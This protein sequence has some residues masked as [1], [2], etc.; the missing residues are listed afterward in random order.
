MRSNVTP[1][2]FF[3]PNIICSVL[4]KSGFLRH[5]SAWVKIR[6][7]VVSKSKR[8]VN[9]SS[10]FSSFFIFTIHNYFVNFRFMY[11]LLWIKGSH[12][13]LNFETFECSGKD[14]PNSSCNFRNCKLVFVFKFCI[15]L[16][17]RETELLG[18]FLAQALYTSFKRSPLK[19]RFLRLLSARVKICQIPHVNFEMTS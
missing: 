1:L 5:L 3:S 15:T 2:N 19:C 7:I 14:L 9:S 11:F 12:K 18:T 6:Q 8:R 13:S 10:N 17:G 4:A 16:Q